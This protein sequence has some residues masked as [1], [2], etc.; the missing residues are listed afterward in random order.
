MQ[1]EWHTATKPLNLEISQIPSLIFAFLQE[2]VHEFSSLT[3]CFVLISETIGGGGGRFSV[4]FSSF[5]CVYNCCF[6]GENMH[7]YG[8]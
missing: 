3:D 6:Y 8:K 7:L 4:R 5:Q 1:K 2:S